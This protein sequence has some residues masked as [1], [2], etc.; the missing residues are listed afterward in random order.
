[1]D[2]DGTS[3]QFSA[4]LRNLGPHPVN[5]TGAQLTYNNG[6]HN[7]MQSAPTTRTFNRYLWGGATMYDA[8]NGTFP[9]NHTFSA[10]YQIAAFAE[11]YFK[12]DFTAASIFG[13]YPSIRSYPVPGAGTPTAV[14]NPAPEPGARLN[15]FWTSDFDA[16]I[17]YDVVPVAGPTVSCTLDVNG[18]SGP[19]IVAQFSANPINS[20]FYIRSVINTNNSN[21]E[22]VYFYIYSTRRGK[23]CIGSKI[24]LH[25]TVSTM[26]VP[27]GRRW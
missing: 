14:V 5:L 18:L 12:W 8:A 13:I 19:S 24:P 7:E 26:T 16:N 20:S 10:P 6:W 11:N 2:K 23:W 15:F 1:M 21:T 22:Y 9:L 25:R 4:Y 3:G 17:S 27:C